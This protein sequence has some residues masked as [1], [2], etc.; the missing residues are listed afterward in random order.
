MPRVHSTFLGY[1]SH[2]L[3]LFSEEN[4]CRKK[5]GGNFYEN[6]TQKTKRLVE[7]AAKIVLYGKKNIF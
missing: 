1:M 4:A 3:C 5:F 6:Q 2:S 7:S